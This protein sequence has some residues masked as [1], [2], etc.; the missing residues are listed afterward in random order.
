MREEYPTTKQ[1]R[2]IMKQACE[3]YNVRII[4]SKTREATYS[5]LPYDQLLHYDYTARRKLRTIE[6][7]LEFDSVEDYKQAVGQVK[8]WLTLSGKVWRSNDRYYS[9][10]YKNDGPISIKVI[11]SI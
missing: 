8:S 7:R 1:L 5:S 3:K 4:Q 9:P 11:C 2:K 6:Y 10:F